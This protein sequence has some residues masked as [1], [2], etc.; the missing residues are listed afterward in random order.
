MLDDFLLM[1]FSLTDLKPH[2][3]MGDQMSSENQ[4][5]AV[6]GDDDDD[7]G[8]S[9]THPLADVIVANSSISGENFI[10]M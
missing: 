10:C 3:P 8:D 4:R 6:A 1:S 7:D 2:K 5:D 9:M